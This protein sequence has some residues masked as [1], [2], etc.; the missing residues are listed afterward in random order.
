MRG[1]GRK[2]KKKEKK[3]GPYLDADEVPRDISIEQIYPLN[4]TRASLLFILFRSS[5]FSEISHI[6]ISLE[7]KIIRSFPARVIAFSNQK[8]I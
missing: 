1:G 5:Y 6:R 4:Y 7:Y 2:K 8:K 3:N